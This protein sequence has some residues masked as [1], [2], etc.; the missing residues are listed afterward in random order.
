METRT[1]NIT[2][3]PLF[4]LDASTT[5][6]TWSAS[7]RSFILPSAAPDI[8]YIFTPSK[9]T[10]SSNGW[11]MNATYGEIFVMERSCLVSAYGGTRMVFLDTN[12][13]S[14]LV[15]TL[16]TLTD[17][18]GPP[19]PRRFGSVCALT[20]D[21]LVVWSGNLDNISV[22]DTYVFNIKSGEWTSSYIGP[23]QLIDDSDAADT[24]RKHTIIVVIVIGV[25]LTVL[26]TSITTYIGATRLSKPRNP[27][28]DSNYSSTIIETSEA[29]SPKRLSQPRNPVHLGFFPD[30]QT[31]EKNY[32]FDRV[33]P[34]PE[35]PHT[36]LPEAQNEEA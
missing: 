16:D 33:T 34:P 23:S 31:R 21:Q 5:H 35:N 27:D 13:Y 32:G 28:G 15:R 11:S 22:N 10:G 19:I 1:T 14:T 30:P 24:D 4:A 17:K 12:G 3:T 6:Y 2:E 29:A 9:V 25:L 20:G 7:L 26:L 8:L 18:F 36:V